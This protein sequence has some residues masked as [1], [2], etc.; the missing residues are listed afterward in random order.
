MFLAIFILFFAGVNQGLQN[1]VILPSFNTLEQRQAET[2]L[3]RVADAIQREVEHLEL[4]ATDW[5]IWDDTYQFAQDQNESFKGSNLTLSTL[6]ENSGINLVFIY[7]IKGKIVWGGAYATLLGGNVELDS[8]PKNGPPKNS[9]LLKHTSLESSR[10]GIHFSSFGPI[11]LA[12]KPIL[13][14]Q[15]E[16]PM[17]GTLIMGRFLD[18]ALLKK[19]AKQ[20]RVKFKAKS[21]NALIPHGTEEGHINE[22]LMGPGAMTVIDEKA[23]EIRG[24]VSGLDHN[25]ALSLI[26]TIPREIMAQG[27][28]A[29]A[30]ASVSIQ[31]SFLLLCLI[32]YLAFYYYT[33]GIRVSND[34]IMELVASRTLELKLAKEEAEELSIAAAAAN[35]SKSVFLANMS[36]EIRTPM[37]AIINLSYLCLQKEMNNKPRDY[38]EKVHGSA[39]ALLRIINDILDFSKVEAGKMNIEKLDFSMCSL[40]EQLALLDVIKKKDRDVQ[41]VFDV[42]PLVPKSLK[43]DVL[44]IHQI[45][46][47][48][49]SNAIKFTLVGEIVLSIRVLEQDDENVTLKFMVEDTGIGMPQEV[50]DKMSEPFVQ[51]DTS[52]TRRFG[53]TGL[54]LVICKQ[55]IQLMGGSFQFLSEEGKGTQAF[56]I[57]KLGVGDIEP[58]VL[59][60]DMKALLLVNDKSLLQS[61]DNTLTAAGASVIGLPELDIEFDNLSDFNVLLI[62]DS[63]PVLKVRA[64]CDE[65]KHQEKQ[66]KVVLLNKQDHLPE[67][68]N[69]DY[70]LNFKKPVYLS[71]LMETL[72]KVNKPEAE[73]ELFNLSSLLF[74]KIGR[75]NI[76]LAE[77]NELNQD[78]I[79]DLLADCGSNVDIANNG[80]EALILLNSRSF[81]VVLMDIQMP[82]MD[83][84][85]ATQ[86]IR[87]NPRWKN[88][89]IIALT[90]N[91]TQSDIEGGMAI[92]MSEYL[93]KPIIPEE[94]FASLARWCTLKQEEELITAVKETCL[95]EKPDEIHGVLGQIETSAVELKGLDIQAG[96]KTCNGKESLFKKLL[97]KF[98]GKYQGL[99]E[100]VVQALNG[101]DSIKAKSI[102]HNLTGV[103]ANIGALQLADVARKIDDALVTEILTGDSAQIKLLSNHLQQ[104]HVSIEQYLANE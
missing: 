82:V 19:L 90:A 38:V 73:H 89:P 21:V 11:I 61:I 31:I 58:S 46:L 99:H 44:R 15:G 3:Q 26:A 88:I 96:L 18:D 39:K 10:A 75:Q 68:L 59:S 13:T 41:L 34:R 66:I 4:L 103:S 12:S 86:K 83:G 53:G 33:Q 48:F 51:A 55:L 50:A 6:S 94:L 17:A 63:F 76:L 79:I 97:V 65:L 40:I 102:V 81:D 29:A 7:D 20:T 45:M 91:A 52:T 93:T 104:V 67:E 77:D 62:D 85:E 28:K 1:W 64:L 71:G 24:M 72:D 8:F 9:D 14:S 84:I 30:L 78:I 74:E 87:Q 95:T 27:L 16:G 56:F 60:S 22:L 100:E 57:L 80:K 43:G 2:E 47:N 54:G 49:L 42:D 98:T 23:I 5:S 35:E 101:G 69:N 70:V 36:H 25:Q 92:G 37:N 32:L